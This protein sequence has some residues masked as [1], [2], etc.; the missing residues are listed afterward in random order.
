MV[1]LIAAAGVFSAALS[2]S[3]QE[4]PENVRVMKDGELVSRAEPVEG[5]PAGD[6]EIIRR[7]FD[8]GNYRTVCSKAED[9]LDDYPESHDARQ[10]AMLWA[11]EAEVKRGRLFQAWEQL[12]D[13][14]ASYPKTEYFGRVL[15]RE[16]EIGDRFIKGEKRIVMGFIPVGARDDGLEILQRLAEHAPRTA[17]AGKALLRVADDRMTNEEY[18]QAVEAY[19]AYLKMFPKSPQAAQAMLQAARAR[20]AEFQGTAYDDRPLLDAQQRFIE[21]KTQFPQQADKNNVEGILADIRSKL[22]EKAY[23]T[24]EYYERTGRTQARLRAAAIY[25]Q[26]VLTKYPQTPWAVQARQGL[27][28]LGVS[29][30]STTATQPAD[31]SPTSQTDRKDGVK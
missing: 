13:L 18:P 2:A 9:F 14:L 17:I 5:T 3:A 30:R 25:Y 22:A 12:E 24:G 7:H 19:D 29:V 8:K 10:Q 21:Y 26:D 28:R 15:N 31:T 20:M 1:I 27:Q 6:L 23:K 4:A 11:A 16:Y